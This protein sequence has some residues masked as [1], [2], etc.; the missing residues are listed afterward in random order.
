MKKIK[1]VITVYG[2]EGKLAEKVLKPIS[3]SNV[4]TV[5]L[6]ISAFTIKKVPWSQK[7]L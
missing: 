7:V 2:K 3:E 1:L 5:E 6:P 4:N